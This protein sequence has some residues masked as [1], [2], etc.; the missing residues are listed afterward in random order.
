MKFQNM[1]RNLQFLKLFPTM[2]KIG[3]FSSESVATNPT[4][5]DPTQRQKRNCIK[6]NLFSI[7]YMKYLHLHC[8]KGL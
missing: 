4:A 6:A 3:Y 2:N 1:R 8:C 7:T 5:L